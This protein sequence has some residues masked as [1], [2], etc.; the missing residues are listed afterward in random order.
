[1]KKKTFISFDYDH[2]LTLKDALVG[3]AKNPDSPF[4]ITDL[5]I[6]EAISSNW[7]ESARRKIRACDVVV[8]ICGEHTSTAS[9]VTAELTIAQEEGIPYFLLQGHPNKYCEKPLHARA[10]DRIQPWTWTNLQSL[11]LRV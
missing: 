6:K 2:A 7:K 1:M 11:F 4:E 5:S 8:V 9:G 3:Q 10:N